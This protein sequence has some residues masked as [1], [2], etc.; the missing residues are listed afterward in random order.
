LL[1]TSVL[2]GDGDPASLDDAMGVMQMF[3]IVIRDAAVGA[4][5]GIPS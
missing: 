4:V 5:E 2:G 3:I 1:I